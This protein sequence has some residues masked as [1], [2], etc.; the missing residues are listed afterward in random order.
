MKKTEKIYLVLLCIIIAVLNLVIGSNH[1]QPKTYMQIAIILVSLTYIMIKK[2]QKE[3]NIII[4]SKIDIAITLLV[5]AT[6]IP[7]IIKSYCSLNDT[8]NYL[9][10]Y[11]CIYAMYILA[12]NVLK[13]QKQINIVIDVT[14]IASTLIV[15]FGLDKLYYNIF[16]DFLEKINSMKS[17]AYGMVSTI[18]YSN[19]LVA[20]MSVLSMF[21]LGRSLCQEKAYKNWYVVYIQIAMIGF[22]FGNSRAMMLI[23]PLIFI[24]YLFLIKDNQKRLLS[25]FTIGSNIVIAYIFQGICKSIVTSNLMLWGIFI[26]DLLFVYVL[27]LVVSKL[28]NKIHIKINK[29]KFFMAVLI[30]LLVC[31][32]YFLIAK[33]I[34]KPIEADEKNEKIFIYGLKN[35][36]SYNIKIDLDYNVQTSETATLSINDYTSKREETLLEEVNLQN[37]NQVLEFNITTSDEFDRIRIKV[38]N[39]EFAINKVTIN[40]IYINGKKYIANYKYLPNSVMR[41]LKSLNFRNVS[42]YERIVFAKDSLNLAKENLIFGAG[43]RTFRNHIKYYQTYQHGYNN[44]SHSYILDLLLNYGLVGIAIYL[45]I[46][47]ITILNICKMVKKYRNSSD[48]SKIKDY[49]MY[50]S[51]V[52]GMFMI[53]LHSIVDYDLEYLVIITMFYMF[54]G[55]MN[56]DDKII[57]GKKATN[58]IRNLIDYAVII[59]FTASLISCIERYHAEYFIS[60]GEYEK[61]YEYC[62]YYDALKYNIILKAYKEEDEE[63]LEKYLLLYVKDEKYKNQFVMYDKFNYLI[64]KK[65]ERND[66]D[67]AIKNLEECYTYITENDN[68]SSVYVEESKIKEIL[69]ER[70][71]HWIEKDPQTLQNE[72]IAGWYN[73]FSSLNSSD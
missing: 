57:E 58:I 25:I 24:M 35:N 40:N 14:L 41:M 5:I 16:A 63:T 10:Q 31:M 39:E 37:G 42:V 60:K 12:R 29:K 4:K 55:V 27:N 56:K 34:E 9:L 52:A 50:I 73:K 61:A 43:G 20:Y 15:I 36:T 28:I 6:A 18:G 45:G 67:G 13:T 44:E 59:V 21:A 38:I 30:I 71:L 48:A 3:K 26:L 47:A 70:T 69:I 2:I 68:I 66:Y 19:P 62:K 65:L 33:N 32:V 54:I 8:I 22:A 51:I 11:I 72:K 23:Y 1:Q 17:S 64:K 7:L 53:I 49:I 46:L